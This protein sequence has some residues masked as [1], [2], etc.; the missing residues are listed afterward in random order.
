MSSEPP[1]SAGAGGGRRRRAGVD[2]GSRSSHTDHRSPSCGPWRV[3]ARAL[4]PST[5]A[6]LEVSGVTVGGL[7]WRSA[8]YWRRRAPPKRRHVRNLGHLGQAQR[9]RRDRRGASRAGPVVLVEP[10]SPEH[11]PMPA[12]G[13]SSRHRHADHFGP[14]SPAPLAA[15]FHAGPG[16]NDAGPFGAAR[17]AA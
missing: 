6:G 10:D 5:Q 16:V 15:P 3:D 11:R 8:Y 2:A 14:Q 17:Q 13:K 9:V 12:P 4:L 7:L 1:T